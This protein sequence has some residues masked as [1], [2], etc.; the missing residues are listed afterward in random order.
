MAC[1]NS[2]EA[3]DELEHEYIHQRFVG[4]PTPEAVSQKCESYLQR[5]FTPERL[6]FALESSPFHANF[7]TAIF[8][9]EFPKP[10][11]VFTSLL[12]LPILNA[13]D[14]NLM[15]AVFQRGLFSAG[16]HPAHSPLKVHPSWDNYPTRQVTLTPRN[17]VPAL[18][19]SGSIPFV[20]A[21]VSAI[22][23]AGPG[24]HVDGGLLDYHFEVETDGPVLYPH[25]SHDP[26]PGW[27][28]RFPPFRRLS[29]R[30]RSQL[31]L[32]VPSQEQL[33]KYPGNFYP[34]RVDF[35]RLSNDERIRR[36]SIT[37]EQ[38]QEMER[39]LTTCLEA[40]DLVNI[41]EPLG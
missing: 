37:A 20:L 30:A 31:C 23:G 18:L 8:P 3:Y 33:A 41:S 29:Q 11:H 25:F 40:D 2:G 12:G 4:K 14:R 22:P 21:G 38:N 26:L 27:M 1:D 17:F 34:G 19:A 39:E 35:Q 6:N 5:V 9:R 28:D 7:T 10:R 13:I 36:W 16:P 32:I 24:H 15:R